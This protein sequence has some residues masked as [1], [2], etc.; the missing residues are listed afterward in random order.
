ML[1]LEKNS[2]EL[3]EAII[4]RDLALNKLLK[5]TWELGIIWSVVLNFVALIYLV[6]FI[7]SWF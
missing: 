6:K 3:V 1:K 5:M 7:W 2:E 4:A